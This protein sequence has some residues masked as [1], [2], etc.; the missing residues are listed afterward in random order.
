MH[1][2]FVPQK[3]VAC[4]LDDLDTDKDK[5]VSIAGRHLLIG[6]QDH[7]RHRTDVESPEDHK[8]PHELFETDPDFAVGKGGAC[9][10]DEGEEKA[11]S[12]EDTTSDVIEEVMT[13]VLVSDLGYH[14]DYDIDE[15]ETTD[16]IIYYVPNGMKISKCLAWLK[17]SVQ[18]NPTN[19]ISPTM[20]ASEVECR[21]R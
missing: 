5:L 13:V 16:Y 11:E 14:S 2:H 20:A 4:E 17:V 3:H 9:Y 1:I 18:P 6:Y 7:Q 12:D 15:G 8:F 21:S 19:D 10:E